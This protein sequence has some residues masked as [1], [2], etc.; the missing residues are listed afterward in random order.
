MRFEFENLNDLYNRILPALSFKKR[1]IK[2]SLTIRVTD[3][4]KNYISGEA[5]KRGWSI[6]EFIRQL[7]REKM[8]Q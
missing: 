5:I 3:A 8:E 2:K 7:I 1:E 4:E 6:S